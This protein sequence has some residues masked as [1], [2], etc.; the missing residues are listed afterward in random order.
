MMSCVVERSESLPDE[1]F[2]IVDKLFYD[3]FDDESPF[4]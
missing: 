1:T 2:D 4:F 3:I